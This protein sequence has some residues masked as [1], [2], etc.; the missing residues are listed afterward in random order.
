ML[1]GLPNTL[2]TPSREEDALNSGKSH[3]ALSKGLSAARHE[4]TSACSGPSHCM[5][6][7]S[8]LGG[9]PADPPQGPLRLLLDAR[10]CV[11]GVEKLVL[12]DRV[13]DVCLKQQAVHLW[14]GGRGEKG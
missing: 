11:D 9:V 14:A 6:A 13:L 5:H 3:Q 4:T 12:V 8:A 10:H 2:H 1:G 7:A